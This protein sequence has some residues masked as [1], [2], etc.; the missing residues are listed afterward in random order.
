MK[1]E[2]P[3]LE[4]E[5]IQASEKKEGNLPATI[6]LVELK[7]ALDKAAEKEGLS[8]PEDRERIEMIKEEVEKTGG[9]LQRIGRSKKFTTIV[10]GGLLSLSLLAATPK[11]SEARGRHHQGGYGWGNVAA[12]AILIGAGVAVS[13]AERHVYERE[14]AYREEMRYQREIEKE[15]I[16]AETERFRIE[17]QTERERLRQET[18]LKREQ[19]RLERDLARAKT[20]KERETIRSR[21]EIIQEALRAKSDKEVELK[22]GGETN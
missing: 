1:E 21:M 3:K 22:M 10:C 19:L 20:D 5:P 14:R 17:A 8:A 16:R 9:V 13:A 7:D 12:A 11:E 15:R 4:S 2:M 18:E 6:E